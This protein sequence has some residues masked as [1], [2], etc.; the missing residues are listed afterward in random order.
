MGELVR[1]SSNEILLSVDAFEKDLFV[2]QSEFP[3]VTENFPI[4]S[5]TAK[6]EFSSIVS[7]NNTPVSIADTS[8][9]TNSLSPAV[10]LDKT[11]T[12]VPHDEKPPIRKRRR[13]TEFTT[14]FT[15]SYKDFSNLDKRQKK[16]VTQPSI[17]MMEQFINSSEYSITLSWYGYG[18]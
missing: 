13:S 7:S 16:N 15:R 4:C 18:N 2:N 17:D 6:F 8:Q 5:S 9:T 11:G 1:R 14:T 3:S 12:N 10:T